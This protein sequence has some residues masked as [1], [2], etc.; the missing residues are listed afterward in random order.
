[1]KPALKKA[2]EPY[3]R[4]APF[5]GIGLAVVAIA[6]AAILFCQRGSQLEMSG[7]ILKVRTLR[8]D[9]RSAAAILDFRV[10]NPSNY[11]VVVCKADTTLVDQS[12]NT[13]EGAAISEIDARQLFEYFPA[14]GQKYNDSLV[15][16][17]K[18]GPHQ[19]LDRMLAARFEVSEKQLK[20]RQ[21]LSIHI[22]DL[23]GPS[24]DLVE[25]GR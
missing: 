14:L 8:L 12:G 15:V 25:Q 24:V 21:R 4:L 18:I 11:T 2:L 13:L 6:L 10:T 9:D 23:D 5:F 16:R 20:A 19:S 1:V 3:I 17:T 7:S 22:E